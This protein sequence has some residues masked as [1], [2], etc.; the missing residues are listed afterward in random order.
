[1]HG[2]YNFFLLVIFFL[3]YTINANSQ[4]YKISGKVIDNNTH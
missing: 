3:I 4:S 1:M 2:S